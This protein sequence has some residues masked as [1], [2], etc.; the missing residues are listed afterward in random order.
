M[1]GIGYPT[2]DDRYKIHRTHRMTDKGYITHR[3]T[4]TG[5]TPPTG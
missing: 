5:Y 2:Q 4:G 1:T 3:V